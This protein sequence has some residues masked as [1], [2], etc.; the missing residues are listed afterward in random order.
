[1]ISSVFQDVRAAFA[2]GWRLKVPFVAANL[3]FNILLAAIFV[4]VMALTVSAALAFS[5]QPALAD[6]DI[7]LFLLSPAGAVGGILLVAMAMVLAVMN[8]AFMMATAHYEH[9]HGSVGLWQG[10][11]TVLPQA[12][13]VLSLAVRLTLHLLVL[14]LPFLALAGFLAARWL[15]DYDIN[16]YLTHQPPIFWQAVWVI[17]SIL[18]IW[19][20]LVLWRLLGWTLSLPLVVFAGTPPGDALAESRVRM[21]GRMWPFL[22][23]LLLWGLI[24]AALFAVG[25]G[26]VTLF[27]DVALA[28][29]PQSTRA[30]VVVLVLLAG[31][32]ALV[33]VLISAITT[34]AVA[35]L[36]VD[37]ADWPRG[38]TE[39]RA[40]PSVLLI[41]IT[42]G[43]LFFGGIGLLGLA[44]L[45]PV[46]DGQ[47]VEVIAHRGAAGAKPEN[48][49]AAIQEAMRVNA[50]WV[51][52][53]VQETADGEVVVMH[54]SDFMKLAGNPLNIWD[55][56]MDDL[57]D[58]DI[59]S[60][61]DP[62]YADERA[63]LLSD[64]L[65]A[66]KD[67]SGVVIEL[68]YYGYD[69]MLEQRVVDIVEAEGMV[70]QVKIM[71][72]KYG[73]VEK[74]RKLRPDWDIG[75]LASASLGQM[76]DLDADFLAVNSATTSHRLV[77]ESHAV[78]KQ[79]YVWTVNDPLSMSA[80]ISL[81][82]D[83]LITD[84]PEL[85]R[86]VLSE[87]RELSGSERLILGL[88]GRIGLDLEA[89]FE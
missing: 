7:A 64:V 24:S 26:A 76:W 77:R 51:E 50:D 27:A 4:P 61:F 13:H 28:I 89:W 38:M 11:A 3:V 74:M 18:A 35:V 66:A 49:M 8:T 29:T 80:M 32:L 47:P 37:E 56:T 67:K 86:T 71:S 82:V 70:E 83:G 14:S 57:A 84:E 36:I 53:D 72:L 23:H 88:A 54:D 31:L 69:D 21:K 10:A 9:C 87:R 48:T 16:Y 65:R 2:T 25:V 40:V 17:G 45:A 81:G 41:A 5:G 68:K 78:G 1:M 59:G 43:A 30:L 22:M 34:G 55:A 85:A 44:D 39:P 60:W 73:A 58:I 19:A 46:D 62:A 6:F 20:A 52:I 75:L 42:A 79:V 33:N 12:L 63:P 15:S